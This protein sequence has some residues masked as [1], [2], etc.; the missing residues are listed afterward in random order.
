LSKHRA[1]AF[2]NWRMSWRQ[3]P[4]ASSRAFDQ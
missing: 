4:E 3:Q 2:D 1:I